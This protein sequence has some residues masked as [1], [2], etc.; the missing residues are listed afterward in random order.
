MQDTFLYIAKR[1]DA[2]DFSNEGRTKNYLAT[3]ARGFAISRYNKEHKIFEI[4]IDDESAYSTE[5]V[6]EGEFDIYDTTIIA[7]A[8]NRLSDENK[9]II[10]LKY[11]YGYKSSEIAAILGISNDAV[12]QRIRKSK[13]QIKKTLESEG[14]ND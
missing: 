7:A 11:V 1:M 4:C 12:R 8:I 6:D 3:V 13:L 14:E 2:L 10:Y 9:N 5:A